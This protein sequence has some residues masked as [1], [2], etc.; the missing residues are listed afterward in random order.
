MSF[1][2]PSQIIRSWGLTKNF[3]AGPTTV[4]KLVPPTYGKVRTPFVQTWREE[5]VSTNL[6]WGSQN[7]SYYL[8]ESLRVISSMFLRIE[9]PLINGHNFKPYAGMYA[10]K[11]VR[12]LSAGQEVYTCDVQAFLRDYCESLSNE[13]LEAF[14][15]IYLGHTSTPGATARSFII[16][17]L[18]PNS[19][20]MQRHGHNT[21]GS[22]IWPCFTAQNRLEVQITLNP[23]TFV[24]LGSNVPASISGKCSIMMHQ[25]DMSSADVLR[26]S[27]LRGTY[28]LINRRFTELTSGWTAATTAVQKWTNSQPVGCVTEVFIIAVGEGVSEALRDTAQVILPTSFK[29][30]ADSVTQKDLNNPDKVQM[31]LYSN[32]FTANSEFNNCARLCFASHA[33]ESTHHYSGGYNMQLASNVSFEFQ[34]A[35]AVDYRL[36]AVQLQRCS[37]DSLGLIRAS[38]E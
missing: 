12:L 38:L 13:E 23:S 4:D 30:V 9:C 16:P 18:L 8:P 7:F 29:V 34:F 21:R 5:T 6:D 28:S 24:S 35:E 36:Y 11:T 2:N 27:D 17:I 15:R 22:G 26:Y 14:G 31:E 33:A 3:A 19:A 25:V 1:E 10:V 37:I 20:Y 32:G